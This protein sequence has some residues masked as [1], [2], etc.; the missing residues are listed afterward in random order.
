MEFRLG[1]RWEVL[2]DL[3][4]AT[5]TELIARDLVQV[6]HLVYHRVGST[7]W[8][9]QVAYMEGWLLVLLQCLMCLCVCVS[10]RSR[11][12]SSK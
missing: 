4:P 7:C 2:D 1:E 11:G 5:E 10:G 8:I 3:I 6:Q 12:M 9:G